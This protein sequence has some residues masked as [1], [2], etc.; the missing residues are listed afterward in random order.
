MG[1]FLPPRLYADI[2]L[3][4]ADA[5]KVLTFEGEVHL[6]GAT[7]EEIVEE[8]HHILDDSIRRAEMQA[9]ATERL[10]EPSRQVA[11]RNTGTPKGSPNT[12]A[13]LYRGYTQAARP[14][15]EWSRSGGQTHGRYSQADWD[16][17]NR[18]RRY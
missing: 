18:S 17:W 8:I 14:W 4:V 15:D 11:A 6:N 2:V 1:A 5:R 3:I 12:A 13:P 7:D 16:Q 10:V 9:M